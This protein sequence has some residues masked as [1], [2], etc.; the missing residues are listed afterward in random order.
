MRSYLQLCY[1]WA[2]FN[3]ILTFYIKEIRSKDKFT[4]DK[5]YSAYNIT[6]LHPY[7][8]ANQWY[9]I[10]QRIA[11]FGE[12]PCKN[13]MEK[14][15]LQKIRSIYLFENNLNEDIINAVTKTIS[16]NDN[17]W[18][19]FVSNEFLLKT[20]LMKFQTKD[21]IFLS[22][23]IIDDVL[24]SNN[25]TF[26]TKVKDSGNQ[27][28]ISCLTYVL[29]SK[30]NKIFKK[31]KRKSNVDGVSFK[32]IKIFS[33]ID[34][35]DFINLEEMDVENTKDVIREIFK[36]NFNTAV[37]PNV[38]NFDLIKKY[39]DIFTLLPLPY[40]PFRKL[41]STLF[42]FITLTIDI[43]CIAFDCELKK[44]LDQI[45]LGELYINVLF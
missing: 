31:Q 17:N 5:D 11:N 41:T 16:I 15:I 30:I 38:L 18:K 35:D 28:F 26:L 7:L 10:S 25:L 33:S 24:E 27:I 45:I 36:N 2:E 42:Y 44:N 21:L 34:E 22:N 43:N 12:E 23:V 13:I 32:S 20:F 9:L 1:N 14:L 40:L 29:M 39:L 19:D 8:T 4:L 37:T 3:V 6:Y